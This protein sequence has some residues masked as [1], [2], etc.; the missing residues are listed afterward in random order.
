M[1]IN[2]GVI[3]LLGQL[4]DRQLASLEETYAKHPYS[5]SLAAALVKAYSLS[6]DVRY[7]EMIQRTA[8]L[9]NDRKVLH[10][11]LFEETEDIETPQVPQSE[12]SIEDESI[13]L[14]QRVDEDAE[15]RIEL[16][17][18]SIEDVQEKVEDPLER[19]FLAEALSAGAALELIDRMDEYEE[20]GSEEVQ[21]P[22]EEI[23][24][25][26]EASVVEPTEDVVKEPVLPEQMSL[27]GWME[28]LSDSPIEMT[29]A[30]SVDVK[31]EVADSTPDLKSFEQAASI[32]DNFIGKEDAI[33]PKRAEFF[34]PA[35]AAKSSILDNEDIV[36]E[37]LAKVYASQGNLS[38]AISTYEKLSLLH[39]EKSSYFA[40]LIEKLKTEKR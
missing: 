35:K 34:N 9:A 24:E 26:D 1:R 38:K 25:P 30:A 2:E 21:A 39:P 18:T 11:F 16:D 15:G 5:A 28:A 19:Q 22:V 14:V 17:E 7:E 13:D 36:T 3:G 23:A 31:Q 12:T 4:T 32:I 27:S 37:T 40:A 10:D 8:L 6:G 29:S 20:E 33:V